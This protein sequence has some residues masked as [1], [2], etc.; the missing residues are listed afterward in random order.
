MGSKRRRPGW[1]RWLWEPAEGGGYGSAPWGV[2]LV[3]LLAFLVIRGLT[4]RTAPRQRAQPKPDRPAPKVAIKVKPIEQVVPG[5][6]VLAYDPRQEREI[7]A[8][9]KA[10]TR[11]RV[12]HLRR[13]KLQ[14]E[15]GHRS[16]EIYTTDDHPFWTKAHRWVPAAE[17][18]PGTILEAPGRAIYVVTLNERIERPEGVDVYNL[19]VEVAHTYYLAIGG[20]PSVLV[21]NLDCVPPPEPGG[22]QVRFGLGPTARGA[23]PVSGTNV[24][25]KTAVKHQEPPL[26]GPF[27]PRLP[28]NA[29]SPRA[30]QQQLERFGNTSAEPGPR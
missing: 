22:W 24:A 5:D 9:V 6:R 18:R 13:L 28:E 29:P 4:S 12:Q 14:S 19:V 26:T 7:V 30:L 23:R 11:R 17:L 20:Q 8:R 21:H 25:G 15:R 3:I 27:A 2:Y 10:V 16:V 1:W